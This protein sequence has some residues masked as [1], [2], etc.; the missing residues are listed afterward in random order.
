MIHKQTGWW[1]RWRLLLRAIDCRETPVP[2][3][4]IGATPRLRP[5]L[6]R[7]TSAAPHF[8]HFPDIST[9]VTMHLGISGRIT[10]HCDDGLWPTT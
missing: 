1:T 10:T 4:L 8:M 9:T 7:P 2:T 5:D 3:P 6:P